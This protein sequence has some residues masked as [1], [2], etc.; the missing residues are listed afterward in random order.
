MNQ[1]YINVELP[2]FIQLL[3]IRR[4]MN[5]CIKHNNDKKNDKKEAIIQKLAN[6]FK[7]NKNIKC[8]DLSKLQRL[9]KMFEYELNHQFICDKSEIYFK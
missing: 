4:I 1:N 8:I 5:R 9:N 3:A 2:S 7:D 6:V